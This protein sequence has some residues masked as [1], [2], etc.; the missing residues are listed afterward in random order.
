MRRL[1]QIK[2]R[3]RR[4]VTGRID[5]GDAPAHD[6]GLV[7]SD[8][9]HK[10]DNL[11]VYIALLDHVLID[12]REMPYARPRERFGAKAAY[13][14]QTEYGDTALMK[15]FDAALSQQECGARILFPHR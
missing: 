3:T 6:F 7:L 9:R 14:A 15:F 4:N 1:G 8:G 11:T 10:R 5:V 12:E 2:E 13:A